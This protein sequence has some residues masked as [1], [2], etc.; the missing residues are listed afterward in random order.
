MIFFFFRCGRAACGSFFCA[1]CL[2]SAPSDDACHRHV[3]RCPHKLGA[4]AYF[5]TV[6][7]F[8]LSNKT[9][10]QRMIAAYL[11]VLKANIRA[12]VLEKCGQTF[13]QLGLELQ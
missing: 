5:A 10:R 12:A 6:E 1:W 9:R 4:D 11:N 13:Q 8:E 2:A 3:A 7:E